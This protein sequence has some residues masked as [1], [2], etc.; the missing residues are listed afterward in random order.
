M[1]L[2]LPWVLVSMVSPGT[3][4]PRILRD[5]YID[6]H[7]TMGYETKPKKKRRGWCMVPALGEL[8]VQSDNSALI[9]L[10]VTTAAIGNPCVCVCVCVC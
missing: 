9:L 10:S 8:I 7:C 6:E 1:G 4:P 3:N 5:N 2:L